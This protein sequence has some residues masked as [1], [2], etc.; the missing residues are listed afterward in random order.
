MLSHYKKINL[1]H[2]I[3]AVLLLYYI[4]PICGHS[5]YAGRYFPLIN[6]DHSTNSIKTYNIPPPSS[7]D[8]DSFRNSKPFRF[9]K[10]I[11]VSISFPAKELS[12]PSKFTDESH[13][14]WKI[15]VFSAGALS[16]SLIFDAWWIPE[17]AEVYVYNN[18]QVCCCIW[19]LIICLLKYQ[20]IKVI[21][22]AFTS[23][24]KNAH[25]FKTSPLKG[26]H[27]V[28]ECVSPLHVKHLPRIHISRIV[29]GY[30]HVS[31][32]G[33]SPGQQQQQQES[34]NN[35][36]SKYQHIFTKRKRHQQSGKCNVDLSCDVAGMDWSNEA[37]SVAVLLTDENQMYCTGVLLNNALHDGRQL[38]LTVSM[39]A[40]T[41]SSWNTYQ[42]ELT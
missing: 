1:S 6:T 37:K 14:R 11:P 7:A 15:K 28:V 18:Q 19:L 32:L 5:G 22:G 25:A 39:K 33:S 35:D 23:S 40:K 13:H 12:P 38:L 27:L 10:S 41:G 26:D 42:S 29:Y 34:H 21:L 3:I 31:F 24:S 2:T 4:Q 16:L 8:V 17:G 36:N 30:K 20:T 9:A